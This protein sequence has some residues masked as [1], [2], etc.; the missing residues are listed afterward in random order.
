MWYLWSLGLT[1][2]ESGIVLDALSYCC[3]CSWA[4]LCNTLFLTPLSTTCCIL[5]T[6]SSTRVLGSE[7]QSQLVSL[8]FLKHTHGWYGTCSI[9]VDVH[10]CRRCLSYSMPSLTQGKPGRIVIMWKHVKIVRQICQGDWPHIYSSWM[11][12]IQYYDFDL[13]SSGKQC[14]VN[15][16]GPWWPMRKKSETLAHSALTRPWWKESVK[17]MVEKAWIPP[18]LYTELNWS[19]NWISYFV[20]S[21]WLFLF[22][23]RLQQVLNVWVN[24]SKICQPLHNCQRP[25]DMKPSP[26]PRRMQRDKR[27]KS[28]GRMP[29]K[30]AFELAK[31][32][33]R[34]KEDEKPKL[35]KKPRFIKVS[36]IKPEQ[37]GLNLQLK[38]VKLLVCQLSAS[39]LPV[40]CQFSARARLRGAHCSCMRQLFYLLLYL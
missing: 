30:R 35:L 32:D 39:C 10:V 28:D 29:W 34:Y 15:L 11:E 9:Q 20:N 14:F 33:P 40:V 23:C 13:W 18:A 16:Y 1:K 7:F 37:K 2:K 21:S 24:S 22:P 25:V 27:C 4:V 3:M 17:V 36:A 8:A 31:F 12:S 38:V 6:P 5:V 26:P 19:Q